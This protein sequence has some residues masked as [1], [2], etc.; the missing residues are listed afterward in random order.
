MQKAL[1]N[2]KSSLNRVLDIVVDIDAHAQDALK[3][4]AIQA[5]HETSLCAATVIL[6][7][8]LES[9]LRELAEEVI[10]DICNRAIPFDNLPAKVR[11]THYWEG[12]LQLREIA[13]R[14]KSES[15]VTLKEALEIAKRLASVGGAHVPYEI[16]WEAFAETRANPG[17]EQIGDF[18]RRFEIADPL[19]TL[20]AAM[21][22]TQ[23][24]LVLSLDSFMKVRHECAHTGSAKIMPTTTDVT[25]YCALIERLGTGIVSVFQ[26]LLG[27]PPY[28][29]PPAVV[30]A[31]GP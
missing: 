1:A 19:P 30:A 10:V 24:T 22:T 20:A 7:G 29:A 6:S 31:P 27:K 23:N 17:P 5:R 28:V 14:E 13:R 26:D 4:Q 11:V 15:P 21:N 25:S 16:I 2:L 18:L 3:D 12:A 8:F 9:F